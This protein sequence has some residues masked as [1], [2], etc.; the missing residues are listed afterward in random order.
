MAEHKP[1]NWAYPF[2]SKEP[3][4]NPL[5][6]MIHMA[7][8]KGG[9]YPTG[10][11]GL[12]HGG[13]HFDEGTAAFF[14]QSSVR[15]IADGEVIAYRIDERYPVSEFTDEIPRVK[16]APFSTGFVLVKHSLQPPP[17]Q[18]ADGS[19][20]DGQT[21]PSLTLYSLYMHLLDWAGYQAQ[22]DLPRP[23]FW[24]TKRYTVN[25]QKD[26]LSVRTGPSKN[27]TKL[28]ELCKGAEITIGET[29]GEFSKLT[30]IISGTAQPPLAADDDGQLPGHVSTSLLKPHSEPTE[31][32]KVVVLKSGLPIKAGDLIGHPGLYQNHDSAAQ[33]M[34]HVELFSCDDVPAFIARS[35]AWASR[36]PDDQKTLLKVY[37]GASK[38]IPHR[39]DINAEN[40]PKLDDDGTQI[41]VELII[42]QSLLDGLPAS[43]KI[44]VKDGADYTVHWWR[45]DGLFADANGNPI[46][47]WLAEQELITTRHS[48]WEWEGFQCIEETG[49]PLE[50]LA[51]AFKARGLLSADEQ[52]NYRVQISSADSAPLTTLARLYE[53]IDS[54]KDGTLTSREIRAA[55]V[56]PWHAQVLGQLVAKYESEWFWNKGK[57]DELDPL[58]AEEPGK[59][60]LVW[61]AEKQ[62]VEKLSWWQEL[63]GP[64]GASDRNAWHFHPTATVSAFL[65]SRRLID[66]EQFIEEYSSQHEQ[67]MANTPAFSQVSKS[68]LR[69]ILELI[70]EY[71]YANPEK[72]N[73][74]ELAYMFATARHEAY[75][76]PSGEFFSS[77]PE[78]GAIPYF[79][80]YDPLLATTHEH[81]I[82]AIENG[83]TQE[84]DG[85]RYRGRGL[86]HLTWKNNYWKAKD[87]FGVDFV[88][89]PDKAAEPKHS[90]PIMIWGMNEGIFTG[91]K[92]SHYINSAGVDYVEARRIINGS[93][94][95]QLIAGY[96]IK[97]ES[98]LRK[99]SSA[100]ESFDP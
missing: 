64:H 32:D 50:K 58:L 53:I 24:E 68:N 84:G 10:E 9:Y 3:N 26:G 74:F 23:A 55:L 62:R 100:K 41:G 6:L 66:V 37:K 65:Y 51:Y 99:T 34:V 54:D 61:E 88:S 17:L 11:N 15:C 73:L 98:I 90:V 40:P 22:P 5:Q 97:F 72:A 43:R 63:E 31:Y 80:K 59:P 45:L 86:V 91:R 35:R 42:P 27:T 7:N 44:Q 56:R 81:R 8:A 93:D 20:T 39:G 87:H 14:D 95:Q 83:N 89:Q 18:N 48:P 38:L 46:D 57:W 21:P 76:F 78:V 13:V 29:E 25:T 28:S 82:R 16:R 33:H 36:L 2:P 85:Y 19:I 47:G 94:Q 12:W 69:T 49:T 70:N 67:F 30:S 71:Y 60:N 4:S 1:I 96:A 52:H 92:L 77:N 79:N 75:Y